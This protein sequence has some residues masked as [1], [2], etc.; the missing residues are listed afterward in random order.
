MR[1]FIRL[2]DS[3]G[4]DERRAIRRRMTGQVME[5]VADVTQGARTVARRKRS[6]RSGILHRK[7]AAGSEVPPPSSLPPPGCGILHRKRAAGP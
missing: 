6:A 4:A 7:R 2:P 3:D 1:S 5:T